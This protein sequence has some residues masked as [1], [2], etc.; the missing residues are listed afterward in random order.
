M[1]VDEICREERVSEVEDLIPEVREIERQRRT[2]LA[3]GIALLL[4]ILLVV[5]LVIAIG[6]RGSSPPLPHGMFGPPSSGL[7][8]TANVP[9][10]LTTYP[11]LDLQG[12]AW[13]VRPRA[14]A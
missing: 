2:G 1:K 12:L 4:A 8:A 10:G 7:L 13:P 11:T 6:G 9:S 3:V 14:S 5:A